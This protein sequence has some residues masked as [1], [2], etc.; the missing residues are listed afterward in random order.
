MLVPGVLF[1]PCLLSPLNNFLCLGVHQCPGQAGVN[2]GNEVDSGVE[3]SQVRERLVHSF[4]DLWG[5]HVES[6]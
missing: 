6:Q 5:Q 2:R 1:T 4:I 3:E